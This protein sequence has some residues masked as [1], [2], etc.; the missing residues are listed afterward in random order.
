MAE[1]TRIRDLDARLGTHETKLKEMNEGLTQTRTEVTQQLT[2]MNTQMD[3]RM[4]GI[5]SRMD[6]LDSN[7]LELKQLILGLQ[8]PPNTPTVS[9]VS[10][11][12]PMQG[13]TTHQ[14]VNHPS[15]SSLFFHATTPNT[16]AHT[17]FTIPPF[18]GPFPRSQT[19]FT[20]TQTPP[21]FVNSTLSTTNP[22]SYTT[23]STRS[24]LQQ[25]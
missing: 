14:E 5:E 11:P 9:T 25:V 22:I 1:G 7:F 13:S 2:D 23:D 18:M 16:V 8:V 20:I 21:H 24:N 3:K 15:S 17:Q 6:R 19:P 4:G 10:E 12:I